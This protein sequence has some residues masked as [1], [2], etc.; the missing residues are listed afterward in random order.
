MLLMAALIV[1]TSYGYEREPARFGRVSEIDGSMQIL[2][3]DAPE[4]E[5]CAIN[6]LIQEGDQL[7]TK[8]NSFA[9]IQFDN[10]SAICLDE[11]TDIQIAE[12]S[13]DYARDE[14][15]TTINIECGNLYVRIP[16]YRRSNIRF[17]VATPTCSILMEDESRVK[18]NVK[19]DG[20]TKILVYEGYADIEAEGGTVSLRR[21]EKVSIDREGFPA[22]IKR[23]SYWDKDSFYRRCVRLD[24]RYTRVC[25]SRRYLAPE[26]I[27]GVV[28]LDYYGYWRYVPTYGYVW[29]PRVSRG[30]RPYYYG[31]WVWTSCGWTWVSYEPW[32]WVPYHYGRWA[33]VIGYGWVWVPGSVWGPGWVVWAEGPGW[34]AWAPLGP[35][36][37]PYDYIYIGSRPICVWTCVYYDSFVK[38]R[39]K[40]ASHLTGK[41]YRTPGYKYYRNVKIEKSVWSKSPPKAKPVY[42]AEV[43]KTTV[44]LRDKF[45]KT[46]VRRDKL[47]TRLNDRDRIVTKNN[48]RINTQRHDD[49]FKD[50]YKRKNTSKMDEIRLRDREN[51]KDTDR[52]Y[53]DKPKS[54]EPNKAHEETVKERATIK[55]K[56]QKVYRCKKKDEI[57]TGRSSKIY[58]REYE[59]RASRSQYRASRSQYR[60]SRSRRQKSQSQYQT[61]QSHYERPCYEKNKE[62]Y[63]TRKCHYNNNNKFY[64]RKRARN[65]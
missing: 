33:Y 62:R 59:V 60:T 34:I 30:W 5:Y 56:N 41:K 18:V 7:S 1:S 22:S 27:I 25:K 4:W 58:W 20:A 11:Y 63:T 54:G 65:Q 48:V 24:R 64:T 57:K 29:I 53:F 19:R 46:Y 26:I 12:L 28:D 52:N 3:Y 8:G 14:E 32:G 21:G 37:T 44:A 36:D 23:L 50:I 42:H 43:K 38:Y 35:Y 16:R 51:L 6:M 10:G 9:E 47:G 49:R 15:V 45:S 39:Y 55:S 31:H 17:E 2:R 61:S 13:K 40:R